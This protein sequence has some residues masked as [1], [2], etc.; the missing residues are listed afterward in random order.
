MAEL[1]PAGVERVFTGLGEPSRIADR[2][3][4]DAC[5]STRVPVTRW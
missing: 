3:Q 5:M 4:W 2:S 1:R